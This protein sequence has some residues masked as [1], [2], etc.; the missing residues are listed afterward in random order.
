MSREPDRFCETRSTLVAGE[1]ATRA[2]HRRA[3]ISCGQSTA[4]SARHLLVPRITPLVRPA[5]ALL[6]DRVAGRRSGGRRNGWI[7]AWLRRAGAASFRRDADA[8]PAA[9]VARAA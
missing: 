5:D 1:P 4:L 7:A 9:E 2:T 8:A 6:C 3:G